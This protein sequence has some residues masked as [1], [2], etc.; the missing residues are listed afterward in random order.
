VDMS[1]RG[2]TMSDERPT[3]K[4]SGSRLFPS[5][6]KEREWWVNWVLAV[7]REEMTDGEPDAEAHPTKQPVAP[8]DQGDARPARWNESIPEPDHPR[9]NYEDAA[10]WDGM[11]VGLD[12]P[13]PDRVLSDEIGVGIIQEPAAETDDLPVTLLDWDDVRRP[14]TGEI[15][16]VC[17]Y[18]LTAV[19]TY[20]E[21]SQSGEG[22][23]QFVYGEVP[24]GLRQFLRHVD[25]EPFVGDDLPMIEMYSGTRLTAMTGQHV[26]DTGT[27]LADGQG[28]IDE[29]CHRF[30]DGTNNSTDAPTDPFAGTDSDDTLDADSVPS[31]EAV[32]DELDDL[33]TYDDDAAPEE[34]DTDRPVKYAAVLRVWERDQKPPNI[35]HWRMMG[36]AAAIG[37]SEGMSRETVIS[38][39]SRYEPEQRVR[40]EVSSIWRKAEAGHAEPPSVQTLKRKG[41]L[42]ESFAHPDELHTD[43]TLSPEQTWGAWSEAR[44]AGEV[45]AQSVVP[46]AALEHIAR[47]RELYNFSDLE[48]DVEELPAKAHNA[49]LYWVKLYRRTG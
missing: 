49:A 11:K 4:P 18:A 37:H 42:P 34:W 35:A 28:L 25:D 46:T 44:A 23:H 47:D 16:P 39:L 8:Y 20:A 14:E 29:L 1:K 12:V 33:A 6:L 26:A 15:H 5:A 9:T 19:D 40:R 22:I 21:I 2:D 43:D 30:G 7:R 27:D 3:A 45:D 31:H 41:L 32:G 36:Y 17:A 10:E 38:D 48:G 13:A 24:G